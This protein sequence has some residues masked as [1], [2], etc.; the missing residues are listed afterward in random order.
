MTTSAANS[1][2][3]MAGKCSNMNWIIDTGASHHV[4]GD[5]SCLFD[6]KSIH[7]WPVGLPNG[8]HSMATLVGNVHLSPSIV[9]HSVLFVPELRCIFLSVSKLI[10][11]SNCLVHFTNSLCV[12]QDQSSR[13]RIGVGERR[14]GLYYFRSD[15]AIYAISPSSITEF[16]LWHRCLGHPSDRVLKL[17]PIIRSSRNKKCLNKACVVCPMAKQ[18]RDAFPN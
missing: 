2:E 6:T 15:P 18:T 7:S 3:R 9:L 14:D 10:D 16:E 8:S 13:T 12:I 4:T 11:E 1:S 17:V 5:V